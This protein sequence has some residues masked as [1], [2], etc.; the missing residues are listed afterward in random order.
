MCLLLCRP[1]VC[2]IVGFICVRVLVLYSHL[3]IIVQ[4]DCNV[5]NQIAIVA[6]HL[7]LVLPARR[8]ASAGTSYGPVSVCLSQVGVL[9]KWID[10]SSWFLAC[11]LLSTCP[12]VVLG[13]ILCDPI[14]SNPSADWP[15]PLQVKKLDPTTGVDKGGPGPP[16]AGQFFLLK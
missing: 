16:M 11:R 1:Q 7:Y 5:Q 9:S 15:N 13:S 2:I 14:Q 8:Y 12:R 6:L 10:G 4:F 3:L